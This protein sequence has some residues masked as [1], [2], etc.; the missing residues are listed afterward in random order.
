MSNESKERIIEL[1][2]ELFIQNGCKRITMDQI[3][4]TLHISKRTLYETFSCKEDLIDECL[5][6]V[7]KKVEENI[8]RIRTTTEDPMLM[9]FYMSKNHTHFCQ[10]YERL[11]D[12]TRDYYPLIFKKYFS[13]KAEEVVAQIQKGLEYAYEKGYIR[14]DANLKI[15]SNAMV[16]F[17]EQVRKSKLLDNNSRHDI[18][19]EFLFTYMRGL[20]SEEAILRYSREEATVR[21]HLIQDVPWLSEH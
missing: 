17:V 8:K 12:D 18:N 7:S 9:I 20:M 3:A 10:K 5:K 15:A 19:S 4:N 2:L 16:Y 11:I 1:A 21:E 14:H 6:S 13:M